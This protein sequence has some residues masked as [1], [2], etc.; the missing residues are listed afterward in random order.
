MQAS[1]PSSIVAMCALAFAAG[2]SAD[3]IRAEIR[4][5]GTTATYKGAAVCANVTWENSDT[6]ETYERAVCTPAPVEGLFDV[7]IPDGADDLD[8]D[9]FAHSGDTFLRFGTDHF[10][11]TQ[12]AKTEEPDGEVMKVDIAVTIE[13]P[14]ID[15]PGL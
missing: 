8:T 14:K 6:H 1:A 2:C 15:D 4:V 9:V 5:H 11:F 12:T 3:V 10:L 7:T 13:G